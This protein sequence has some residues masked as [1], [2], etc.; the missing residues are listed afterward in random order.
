MAKQITEPRIADFSIADFLAALAAESGASSATIAAYQSDLE[1]AHAAL[2]AKQT[3]LVAASVSDLQNLLAH[4]HSQ[5]VAPRT[6]ARRLSALR[7]YFAY[8]CAEKIRQDNPTLQLESPKNT[9]HL[10]ASLSEEEV[11]RLLEAAQKLPEEEM[12]LMMS[13]GLELLYA[14]GLRISELLDLKIG[15]IQ[16]SEASLTVMG[17]GRK[18][19][20]VLVTDLS[21]EK[22]ALWL[23]WRDRHQSDVTLTA[24]FTN[25]KKPVN[26]AQFARWLKKIAVIAGISPDKISPHKLR[27]SFATHML[28]RG[29]DLRSLQT[30]LG[31]AD[32]ATT[33]IYTKTRNDRLSGL[34][35]DM[36]PLASKRD[37]ALE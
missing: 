23:D 10:P 27:H 9:S 35:S 15:D 31:H 2:V 24:L 8:L 12:A 22:I 17:K 13:A 6:A 33:Q 16:K 32:I 1:N 3:T 30:M 4:W 14:T 18:E 5:Q 25:R 20:V 28:N 19:R 34:V 7:Q 21:L 26:R 11:I 29:A 36:H 37:G